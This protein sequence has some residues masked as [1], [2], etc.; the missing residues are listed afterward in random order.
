MQSWG[1]D[2]KF[3]RRITQ[4]EPTKSGVLGLV[5]A[6][7]GRSREDTLVDLTELRFGTRGDQPGKIIKDFH[8]AQTAD[9]RVSYI[10]DRYYLADA[11][12]LVGLEGDL[13]LLQEVEFALEHPVFPLYLGRR[14]CPPEGKVSLGLRNLPLEEAL[15]GEPWQAMEWFQKRTPK[16]FN[17]EMVLDARLPGGSRRRDQPVSFS[18]SHRQHAFRHVDFR[19]YKMNNLFAKAD[20]KNERSSRDEHDPML[21]LEE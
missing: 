3:E 17:I 2:S 13:R 18:Q 21:E 14:S 4:R 1:I 9:G 10:T 5:A 7:L 19:I 20:P 12:F 15:L 16:D 8:T 11:V 6:A